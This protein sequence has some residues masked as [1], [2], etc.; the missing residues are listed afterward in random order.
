[1]MCHEFDGSKTSLSSELSFKPKIY[2][3]SFSEAKVREKLK[4]HTAFIKTEFDQR[5]LCIKRTKRGASND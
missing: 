4:F 5:A 1:M 2:L 3:D